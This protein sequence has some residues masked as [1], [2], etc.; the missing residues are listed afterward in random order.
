MRD[1]KNRDNPM[2]VAELKQLA[3]AF[4]WDAY[5]AA[6]GAPAFTRLNVRSRPF[7]EDG[8][9]VVEGTPRRGLEDVPALARRATRAAPYL[10][11]AFVQEDFRFN[12][13]VP[14][15][16]EGDRAALEALRAGDR[17]RARRRARAASTSRR[18]SAP[19]AR[20]A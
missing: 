2:T 1:P 6:T 8:N 13:A 12:R 4:D 19:T 10:G 18:P 14:A 9:A 17:P 15:R 20:R 7:F 3:P 11:A 5:F 16:R